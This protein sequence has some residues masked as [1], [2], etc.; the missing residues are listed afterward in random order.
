MSSKTWDSSYEW[1]AVLILSLAFG[2]VGI[3]RFV[4]PP[5]FPSMMGELHLNYQDLGNLVGALG[6]AWGASAIL[7]GNLS[8]RLGRRR[9]L[10]PAVV[11]F[12]VLSVLSGFAAGLASL[13]A[14]RAVMG[15][16]E[17]P[18]A[19]TGVAV[20][21]EASH[22]KRRGMNNGFF[23]CTIALFGIGLAP[24]LATQ[25]LKFTSWRA[26]FW[27]VGTPGLIVAIIMA[28]II[29]EPTSIARAQR[30]AKS[31]RAPIGAMFRHRNVPLSMVGLLCAMTGVFVLS[32]VMPN[33]LVDYLKLTQPQMG[34]VTSAIGFGGSL[35]QLG[36]L[37]LSDF[38]GRRTATLLS[39]AISAVFLWLF[40]HT[41]VNLPMLFGLLSIAAMFN[42]GALA[43]LAGPIPAEAAPIG[44]IASVAGIVI[45]AGEIFGGGVA[46]SLAGTIA[47]RFGIQYTL[48]FALAGQVAGLA[49]TAFLH[50]TAP[51][52]S[53]SSR[54]GAISELDKMPEVTL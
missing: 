9:V 54:R 5:L 43:I 46:P 34:L 18:V 27:I 3:D 19:S 52:K 16:A 37:T 35:G 28:F 15:L 1:R 32:A 30:G 4:L 44:L 2:L 13:I 40:I 51:R 8:D 31:P 22:P 20:A 23:Q 7:V 45:G 47:Q 38:I 53:G 26:V 17:G 21:V 14:I 49:I 25:L 33:Y 12:S 39:F 10:V 29:R 42:F 6:V 50:E 41:G 24:I 11:I 36:L 48:Y